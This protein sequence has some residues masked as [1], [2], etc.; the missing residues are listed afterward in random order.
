MIWHDSLLFLC[1]DLRL[2]DEYGPRGVDDRDEREY[3]QYRSGRGDS[4]SGIVDG[5]FAIIFTVCGGDAG[6]PARLFADGPVWSPTRIFVWCGNFYNS[7]HDSGPGDHYRPVWYVRDGICAFGGRAW[8]CPV[9]SLRSSRRVAR[10]G[11]TKSGQLCPSGWFG[12]GL[13]RAGD[14]LSFC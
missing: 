6:D 7:H 5:N 8:C 2:A 13:N 9:L 4:G 1:F 12:G 14:R 3:H 10:S 11:K